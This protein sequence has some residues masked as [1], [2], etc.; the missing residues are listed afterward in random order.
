MIDS[1]SQDT[2][3]EI[4]IV[5]N[6]MRC[7]RKAELYGIIFGAEVFT[8]D[9]ISVSSENTNILLRYS[10]LIKEF[11]TGTYINESERI[12]LI[13]KE[14]VDLIKD[15]LEISSC[16]V[17]N[18]GTDAFKCE[19]CAWSFV[20]GMFL[21]CGTLTSPENAYHLEFA[22]DSEKKA[23]AFFSFCDNLSIF[24]RKV[25]RGD[26]LWGIYFKDSET[27]VDILGHIGANRAAFDIL[28]VK[29]Y[30]DIRNN[31]NRI[32]NCEFANMEKTV[33]ASNDQVHAIEK[34][35]ISGK[36][37]E[38]P[39]EL[40]KTLDIRI[41]FPSATLS[42]LAEKHE[43]PITKSGVNHRLKRLVEFSKKC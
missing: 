20:R 7:C 15:A 32:S 4:C 21:S 5:K 37:D 28:N 38:L 34:I 30:K 19:F 13:G 36:A 23:D 29:I 41:A 26:C 33:A 2:K 24:P 18:I 16:S 6:K 35:I 10:K 27:I 31:V 39:D 8:D 9:S 43:P 22:F 14:S 1:F 40:K 42:E 12:K 11:Y 25:E 3:N 17:E